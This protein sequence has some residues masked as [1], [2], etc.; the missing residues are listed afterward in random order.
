MGKKRHKNQ[1]KCNFSLKME[2]NIYHEY[3]KNILQHCHPL[4]HQRDYLHIYKLMNKHDFIIC[5]LIIFKWSSQMS[6]IQSRI[7]F[8][9]ARIFTI[10]IFYSTLSKHEKCDR[11]QLLFFVY[12]RWATEK[13]NMS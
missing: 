2:K 10:I 13:I 11:C 1:R 8:K 6:F 7:I 5:T 12:M 3:E 9:T 4:Q